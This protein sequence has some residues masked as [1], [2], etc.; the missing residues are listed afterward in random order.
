MNI[1]EPANNVL[2][3]PFIEIQDETWLKSALC[4]WDVVYRIVPA[5]YTPKDSDEVAEA[6]QAGKVERTLS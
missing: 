4:I 6:V 5:G 1:P 2:Y 3:Y